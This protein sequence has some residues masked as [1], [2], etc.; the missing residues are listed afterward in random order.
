VSA[1]TRREGRTYAKLHDGRNLIAPDTYLLGITRPKAPEA[2]EEPLE[3]F[4]GAVYA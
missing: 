1:V 2:P 3:A 4:Y